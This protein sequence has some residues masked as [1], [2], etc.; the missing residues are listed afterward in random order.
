MEGRYGGT[1]PLPLATLS[2]CTLRER[3]REQRL[4]MMLLLL[5]LE[6]L[7]ERDEIRWRHVLIK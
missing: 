5:F 4:L 1:T 7:K 2:A 3:E 6:N